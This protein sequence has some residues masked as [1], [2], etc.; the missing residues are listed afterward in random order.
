MML[1]EKINTAIERIRKCERLALKYSTD[2]ICVLFS[3]GKDSQCVLELTK[4]A[5]GK[6]TADF[7]NTTI[8]YPENIRFIKKH[9]PEVTIHRPKRTF[10]QLCIKQHCLPSRFRRFCCVE[11]KETFGAGRLCVT[12]VRRAESAKRVKRAEVTE[13]RGGKIKATYETKEIEHKCIKGVDKI[14]VNP[15]IDWT[16]RDVWTFIKQRKLPVNP[17]YTFANRVGCV[18]CPLALPKNRISDSIRY[19]AYVKMIRYIIDKLK[20]EN[21]FFFLKYTSDVLLKAYL[22][23]TSPEKIKN[24]MNEPRLF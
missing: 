15:I 20:K 4:M 5:G 12:G 16:Y 3:G 2:G 22:T 18:M 17:C 8:E 19:P 13:W 21:V 9:Y 23:D 10:V 7:S 11:L 14:I 1:E 6:Y 24:E